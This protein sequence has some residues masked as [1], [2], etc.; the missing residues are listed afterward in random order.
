M[1]TSTPAISPL[2]AHGGRSTFV[3]DV[4]DAYRGIT[5]RGRCELLDALLAITAAAKTPV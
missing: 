5:A 4:V 3:V 1:Y 2:H